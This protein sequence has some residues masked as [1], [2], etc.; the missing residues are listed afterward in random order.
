M[1]NEAINTIKAV[2]I[3]NEQ[4]LGKKY[5]MSHKMRLEKIFND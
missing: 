2:L 1:K 3:F 5:S 4:Y